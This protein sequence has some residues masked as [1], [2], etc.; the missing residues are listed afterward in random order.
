MAHQANGQA[1][2]RIESSYKKVSRTLIPRPGEVHVWY[3]RV[4]TTPDL[5]NELNSTLSQAERDRAGRFISDR[6]KADYIFARGVLRDLLSRATGI[7]PGRIS[8]ITSG[9]GKPSLAKESASAN[10]QFNVSHTRDLVAVG[11]TPKRAI[12]IDIEFV[13][14]ATDLR[15]VA[16]GNYTAGELGLIDS[17]CAE[18]SASLL[19]QYWTRKESYIKA[20]GKGLSIPLN[21]FDT[22]FP[23]G[24]RGC[25]LARTPDAPAVAQWWI[26]DLATPMDY[27]GAITVEQGLDRIEYFDWLPR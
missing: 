12:G 14:R 19:F 24:S 23:A 16:E 1:G 20:V 13:R 22:R 27:A 15:S 11:L 18:A 17:A 25:V 2:S 6:H 10:L 8:F 21:S 3:A 7:A 5:Q 26:E 9:F 4:D